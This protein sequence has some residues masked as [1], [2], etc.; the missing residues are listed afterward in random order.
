MFIGQKG[1]DVNGGRGGR[2]RQGC[3]SYGCQLR[4]GCR[5]Y[6][7]RAELL[8]D[9][10]DGADVVGDVVAGLAVAA[11]DGVDEAAIFIAQRDSDTIDFGL[12]GDGDVFWFG[13]VTLQVLAQALIELDEFLFGSGGPGFGEGIGAQ[14]KHVVDAEHRHRV[15]D[16]LKT[17]DG[18]AAD[19]LGGG[20]RVVQLGVEFL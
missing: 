17:R 6:G 11:G 3:R 1:V 7:W 20:V 14:L 10:A 9:A 13:I 8:G 2:L 15:A 12:D 4:Q 16:F 18:R 19:A 5:S